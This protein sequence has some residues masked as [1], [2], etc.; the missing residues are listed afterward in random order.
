VPETVPL[1]DTDDR[2]CGTPPRGGLRSEP[3]RTAVMG[4]LQ[5][6]D[7]AQEALLLHAPLSGLLRV[8]GQDHLDV[9][10]GDLE[11]DARIIGP[12]LRRAVGRVLRWPEHSHRGGAD[13]KGVARPE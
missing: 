11:H 2:D 5:N 4:Q 13:L 10:H 6:L 1:A 9:A 12:E 8:P 7:P 3:V